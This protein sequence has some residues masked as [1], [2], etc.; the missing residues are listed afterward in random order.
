MR[1]LAPAVLLIP[2]FAAVARADDVHLNNGRTLSGRVIAQTDA[3]VRLEVA[4]GT[5][6]VPRHLVARIVERTP[7]DERYAELFSA[8]DRD[9]PAQVAGLAVWA[10]RNGLGKQAE[11]LRA[12][13]RDLELRAQV[14]RVRGSGSAQA[15]L[16]VLAWATRRGYSRPVRRWLASKALEVDPGH[17]EATRALA[18]IDAEEQ[19][20]ARARR[21][22]AARELDRQAI[23]A[24]AAE[25]QAQ[26]EQQ[27]RVEALERQL[28]AQRDEAERLRARV[29][30]L[31]QDR[32][33]ARRWQIA[34][35]RRRRRR[36][37]PPP[38]DED[39]P[40]GPVLQPRWHHAGWRKR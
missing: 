18:A 3:V 40:R 8:L 23:A 30:D 17:D 14:D 5:M 39:Q 12:L 6:E 10:S 24:R 25:E 33:H 38:V 27:E 9:D 37:P 34:V 13:A 22:E 4:G 36:P 28:Q 32:E 31:E 19:R 29:R 26:R 11:E 20:E 21:E 2:L 16:G 1:T 35:R 7:P 15:F